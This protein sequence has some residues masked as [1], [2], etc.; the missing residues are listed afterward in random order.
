MRFH[1]GLVDGIVAVARRYADLPVVL[2]GGCFQN[3]VLSELVVERFEGARPL[4]LPRVIPA[5]DG[6]LAAGQLAVAAA[7]IEGRS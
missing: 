7:R 2:C 6:G 5:G 1:R 3:Q 4:A